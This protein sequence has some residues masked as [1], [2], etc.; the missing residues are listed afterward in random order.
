M[1]DFW[2]VGRGWKWNWVRPLLPNLSLLKLSSTVINPLSLEGD[3]MGWLNAKGGV[4]SVKSAYDLEM[5]E[6]SRV[7][8]EVGI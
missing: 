1:Y 2:E 8:G 7:N 5:G 4:Y 6:L 3:K